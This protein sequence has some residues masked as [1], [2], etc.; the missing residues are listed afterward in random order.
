MDV[1][2][3]KVGSFDG[4]QFVYIISHDTIT[5]YKKTK[6]LVHFLS[7]KYTISFLGSVVW[8]MPEPILTHLSM[9]HAKVFCEVTRNPTD[10]NL[11]HNTFLECMWHVASKWNRGTISLNKQLE[12]MLGLWTLCSKFWILVYSQIF[13]LL[14]YLKAC[15]THYYAHNS[16]LHSSIQS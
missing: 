16:S 8:I 14:L 9:H 4:N 13:F 3:E 10:E 1:V 11:I 12:I 6:P 5:G 7:A 15:C 2:Y